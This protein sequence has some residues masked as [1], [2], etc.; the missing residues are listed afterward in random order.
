MYRRVQ[1]HGCK[2]CQMNQNI[3]YIQS[4]LIL[5]SM[6]IDVSY[7]ELILLLKVSSIRF[8]LPN[9]ISFKKLF[10][11]WGNWDTFSLLDELHNCFISYLLPNVPLMF[12]M[13]QEENRINVNPVTKLIKSNFTKFYCVFWYTNLIFS[14]I[15][16][17]HAIVRQ[18]DNQNW[19]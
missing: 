6:V 17:H 8:H 14:L 19:H 15:R 16:L 10:F 12:K 11:S 2:I 1:R 4:W 18:S 5:H 9:L 7:N 3:I 13:R